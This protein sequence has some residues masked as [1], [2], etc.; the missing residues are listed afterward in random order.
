MRY[1]EISDLPT[2]IRNSLPVTAQQAYLK[3]FNQ[4]W[5]QFKDDPA[6]AG[7]K[8]R[9]TNAHNMAWEAVA[10]YRRAGKTAVPSPTTD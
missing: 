3:V 2:Q 6:V 7:E 9:E 1:R 8:E 4:A 5:M 10:D